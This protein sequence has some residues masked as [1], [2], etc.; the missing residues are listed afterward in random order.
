[1]DGIDLSHIRVMFNGAEPISVKLC[2]DFLETL[3]PFGMNPKAMFP[4]YGLAEASLAASF[5]KVGQGMESVRVLRTNLEIH[6]AVKYASEDDSNILVFPKE[7]KPVYQCEIRITDENREIL[8]ENTIGFVEIKGDNVTTGYYGE[9]EL[10]QQF[11]SPQGWLNTGDLGFLKDGEL[12]ISGRDKDIIFVN[13]QNFFPHDIEQLL[14]K[15]KEVELGKIAVCGV[16]EKDADEDTV[17]A[18]VLF[19][20]K[21]EK[22]LPL[23]Q[24]IKKEVNQQ[25]AIL[26]HQVI[27]VNKIPK[28]TSGKIQRYILSTNFVEGVYSVVIKELDQL[29]EVS[30]PGKE[31]SSQIESELV[32]ICSSLIPG[33]DISVDD[34][35]FDIGTTSLTLAQIHQKIDELYPGKLDITDFFEYPTIAQLS[36]FLEQ[37]QVNQT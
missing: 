23:I 18:F 32:T 17:L 6:Q 21:K 28:T 16:R 34:N 9:P 7:G 12:V 10:N 19:K 24:K 37:K 3:A 30:E 13:G 31:A 33:K 2:D 20:G 25:L 15:I 27:P 14:E 1:M 22:F 5:P 11:I 36:T 26:V 4:V 8:P 35:I 29:A